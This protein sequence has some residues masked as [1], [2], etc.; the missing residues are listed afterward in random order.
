MLKG[1][2]INL[3]QII[4]QENWQV[5]GVEETLLPPPFATVDISLGAMSSP[6]QNST[7]HRPCYQWLPDFP[8]ALKLC[9][10]HVA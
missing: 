4:C 3:G 1:T 2:I 8:L 7:A 10:K 5:V 6:V 9:G